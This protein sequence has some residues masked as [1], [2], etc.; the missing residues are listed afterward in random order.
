M[1][2]ICHYHSN[3]FLCMIRP[4]R[5]QYIYLFLSYKQKQ[6]NQICTKSWPSNLIAS[7]FEQLASQQPR[8][9]LTLAFH[10]CPSQA[11]RIS[12]SQP[13]SSGIEET[14]HISVEHGI[15]Q[16]KLDVY[17]FSQV[18]SSGFCWVGGFY[19][20]NL[21]IQDVKIVMQGF[22]WCFSSFERSVLSFYLILL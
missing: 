10:K 20:K 12:D 2:Q 15:V 17:S 16:K 1:N 13:L 7:K 8:V 9:P 5:A 6:F 11:T 3:G 4:L 14:V 22:G 21:G 19:Q 18:F